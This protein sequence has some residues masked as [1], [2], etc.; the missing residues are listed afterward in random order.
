MVTGPRGAGKSTLC[1]LIGAEVARRGFRV[2]GVITERAE[3]L[4]DVPAGAPLPLGTQRAIAGIVPAQTD[5]RNLLDLS[6]GDRV[7]FG[8][9]NT[10]EGLVGDPLTPGWEFGREA[11]AFADRAIAVAADADLLVVDE[12]GPLELRGGRG[13]T[14]AVP[15][16]AAARFQA[17]LVVCRPELLEE[18][19]VALHPEEES[20]VFLLT[21]ENQSAM[22]PVV[23]EELLGT[24]SFSG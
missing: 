22:L 17:A 3:A 14:A 21:A 15:V 8:R 16:L 5:N 19:E 13:F 18:L 24:L 4:S 23:A 12:V 2:G 11:F 6:S 9:R 1:A 20:R 10:A 7:V